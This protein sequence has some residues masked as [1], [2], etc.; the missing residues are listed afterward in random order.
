[1]QK[2][3]GNTTVTAKEWK[4]GTRHRIYF[5][6]EG[7]GQACWDAVAKSWIKVHSEFGAR[8]KHQIKVAF[9]L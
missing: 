3:I 9:E 2:I 1:M 7:R 4:K 8:F 5:S 6:A